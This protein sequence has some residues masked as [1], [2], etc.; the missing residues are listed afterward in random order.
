MLAISSKLSL[1]YEARYLALETFD[2]YNQ[3]R[4]SLGESGGDIWGGVS[5]ARM[6][7]AGVEFLGSGQ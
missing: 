3:W 1:T 4:R 6:A 2:R 5:K 7:E